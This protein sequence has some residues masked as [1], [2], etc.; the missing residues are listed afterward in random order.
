VYADNRGAA[1]DAVWVN[2]NDAGL[3]RY[4]EHITREPR[5]PRDSGGHF[6]EPTRRD[7]LAMESP[8]ANGGNQDTSGQCRDASWYA[9]QC[10]CE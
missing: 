7:A 9:E 1:E 3:F 6:T 2:G 10:P 8:L 4:F 5:V